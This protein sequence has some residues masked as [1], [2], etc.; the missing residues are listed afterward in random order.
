MVLVSGTTFN[1]TGSYTYAE[2]GSYPVTVHINSTD[3]SGSATAT[4]TTV[5]VSDATLTANAVAN[6]LV[7]T[8]GTSTGN[9]VLATFSDAN[10]TAPISDFSGTINWGD[11]SPLQNFT[12]ANYQPGGVGNPFNDR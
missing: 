11:G 2:E 8:E 1:V 12:S 9:Q 6:P 7:A 4:N 10:P 3:G 5:T